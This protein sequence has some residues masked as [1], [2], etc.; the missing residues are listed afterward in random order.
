MSNGRYL[1]SRSFQYLETVWT[2][3]W[4]DQTDYSIISSK[5]DYWIVN[6]VYFVDI[7]IQIKNS[8]YKTQHK[9]CEET[10]QFGFK[11]WTFL[12]QYVMTQEWQIE[13]LIHFSIRKTAKFRWQTELSKIFTFCGSLPTC[14]DFCWFNIN[15]GI[16]WFI[17]N[18]SNLN[19]IVDMLSSIHRH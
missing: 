16:Q 2:V 9:L 8:H 10:F 17:K 15:F 5:N 6:V 14:I 11:P 19:I 13:K 18:N 7:Q 1:K 3:P 4:T 12:C